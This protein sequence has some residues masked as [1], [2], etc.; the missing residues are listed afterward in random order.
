MKK[1][2]LFTIIL[3]ITISNAQNINF[4][5][6]SGLNI[7]NLRGVSEEEILNSKSKFGFHIGGFMEFKISKDLKFH[8][9]LLF[10]YQGGTS[11]FIDTPVVYSNFYLGVNNINFIRT[12]KLNYLIIPMMLKYKLSNKFNIE[13]GPQIGYLISGKS[14]LEYL[15][16]MNPINNQII[17]VDVSEKVEYN[18]DGLPYNLKAFANKFD[19]G[20]NLGGSYD[21]TDSIYIQGL[22]N[23][24]LTSVEE[25]KI[26]FSTAYAENWNIKNSVFQLSLGYRFLKS[27]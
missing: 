3:Y 2:I 27:K 15:N 21:L 11:E 14:K 10:S 17:E 8:P 24:G 20:V 23:L 16:R 7:S 1:Y 19:F 22:Y 12:Y 5:I 4:G 26:Y 13:F 18:L 9:E 6:K 25:S